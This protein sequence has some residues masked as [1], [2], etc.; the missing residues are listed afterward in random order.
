MSFIEW[1]DDYSVNVQEIDEQHKKLV[2]MINDLHE[3]MVSGHGQDIMRDL[4]NRIVEY[5]QVHFAT[6]EKYMELYQFSE[7]EEHKKEHDVFSREANELNEKMN[8]F[9]FV[10]PMNVMYFL[11]NWLTTHILETDKKYI[12]IFK[13]NGLN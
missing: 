13:R 9:G 3:A 1:K 12:S 6:E 11:S 8:K 10:L 7:Y 2:Q 5:S 4:V